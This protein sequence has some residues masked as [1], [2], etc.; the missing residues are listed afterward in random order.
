MLFKEEVFVPKK[1]HIIRLKVS[2]F[3]NEA[4]T[5]NHTIAEKSCRAA[6]SKNLAIIYSVLRQHV[7]VFI[8]DE[9]RVCKSLD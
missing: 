2:F 6:F 8:L 7:M 4:L 9:G 3:W 5:W 1:E